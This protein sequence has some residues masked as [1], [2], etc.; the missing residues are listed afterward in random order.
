[1]WKNKFAISY[2]PAF[3]F[4]TFFQTTHM[5]QHKPSTTNSLAGAA[6]ASSTN[7]SSA[8]EAKYRAKIRQLQEAFPTFSS[9][10]TPFS[11]YGCSFSG[12]LF[13][14]CTSRPFQKLS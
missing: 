14:H 1:M 5:S 3:Y 2:T 4:C 6:P 11:I 10:G 13:V 8:T 12:V 9:D 7:A